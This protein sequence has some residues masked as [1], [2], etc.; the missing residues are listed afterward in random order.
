MNQVA[1]RFSESPANLHE[2]SILLSKCAEFSR[3]LTTNNT[4]ATEVSRPSP[5][6]RLLDQPVQLAHHIYRARRERE[7]HFP[8][9]MADPA[10]DLLLDLFIAGEEHRRVSVTS[11]C[12]AAAVPATTALRWIGILTKQGL[13]ERNVDPDDG[14]KTYLSLSPSAHSKT[15]EWLERFGR[16]LK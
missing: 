16:V 11:A 14:R 15:V 10:W 3:R 8:N 9:L 12:I 2:L 7:R 5:P 1:Q 4:I 13:I 6:Q